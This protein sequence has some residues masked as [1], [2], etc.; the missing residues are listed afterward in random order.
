MA[1]GLWRPKDPS[2]RT[3]QCWR[4]PKPI[5][6]VPAGP[7]PPDIGR[8]GLSPTS[9]GDFGMTGA[10]IDNDVLIKTACYSLL[11]EVSQQH[12]GTGSVNVLGAARFVVPARL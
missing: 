9:L 12:R 5:S 4:S 10:A 7:R 8:A 3:N 11:M 6:D 1:S 2:P